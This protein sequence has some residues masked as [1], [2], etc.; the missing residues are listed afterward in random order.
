[1]TSTKTAIL[2]IQMAVTIIGYAAAIVALIEVGWALEVKVLIVCAVTAGYFSVARPLQGLLIH[3][4]HIVHWSRLT[5]ISLEIRN[6]EDGLEPA[7][8]RFELDREGEVRREQDADLMGA[9]TSIHV[10]LAMTL[11]IILLAFF[12][13]E[14]DLL[15]AMRSFSRYGFGTYLGIN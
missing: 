7:M 2:F 4:S 11:A 14:Y 12:A 5:F 13:I 3:A 9:D 6:E 1:M 10:W 8:E 15:E